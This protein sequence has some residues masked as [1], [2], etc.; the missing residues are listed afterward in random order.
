MNGR[1]NVLS[2]TADFTGIAFLTEA[3]HLSPLISRLRVQTSSQADAEWDLDYDFKKNRVNASTALVNYHVGDFTFGGGDAYVQALPGVVNTIA[4]QRDFNQFRVLFGY[5][6]PNKRGFS[7]ASSIGFDA[8]LGF[9]QYATAQTTYNWDCCG[10]TL[11]YRRF[12]LGSVRNENQFR[13]SF[14]LANVRRL[15]QP[16]QARTPVLTIGIRFGA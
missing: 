4:T 9:L 2:T 3:R 12:A 1:R 6:H 15:R 14:T 13:F 7:G 16:P 5:G 11:E 10:V 8:N